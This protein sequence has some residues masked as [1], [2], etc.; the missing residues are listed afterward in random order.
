MK[1]FIIQ[2]GTPVFG[3][4]P[5]GWGIPVIEEKTMNEDKMYFLEDIAIDPLG[6]HGIS[7]QN[8]FVAHFAGEGYYGFRIPENSK[9][10]EFILV[11][12]KYVDVK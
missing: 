1:A 7:P 2:E 9:G 10:Y 5:N 6:K 11:H 3:V 8:K 4:K 12:S